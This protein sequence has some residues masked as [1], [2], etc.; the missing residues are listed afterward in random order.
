MKKLIIVLI[1]LV[2]ATGSL[3]A[4]TQFFNLAYQNYGEY[5]GTNFHR[6]SWGFSYTYL[7]EESGGLYAQVVPYLTTASKTEGFDAYK[8]WKNDLFGGGLNFTIG[9][10]MDYHNVEE[11]GL[12]F[13]GGFFTDL[14]AYRYSPTDFLFY[15]AKFGLAGGLRFYYL[16]GGG[17]EVNPLSVNIG[18]DLAWHPLFLYGSNDFGFEEFIFEP[19]LFTYIISLGVGYHY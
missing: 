16:F 1:V 10:G 3:A 14:F 2:A 7:Q 19:L 15:N 12:V 13:G 8:Y 9:Y 17:R 5:E 4:T 6:R 11:Y 18:F